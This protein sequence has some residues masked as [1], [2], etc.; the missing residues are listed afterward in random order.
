MESFVLQDW[1]TIRGASG[2][3]VTQGES[4]WLDLAPYEDIV[5]W[6]LVSEVTGTPTPVLLFQ[7]APTK[8]ESFFAAQ[9]LGMTG[10]SVSLVPG[11]ATSGITP[12][13]AWS[14]PFPLARY[15]RWQ[16]P[17]VTS[18]WDVTLRIMVSVS[19]PRT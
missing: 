3:T 7:T 1:V 18:A 11:S 6:L 8:D 9:T 16:I 5:F 17:A 13:F 14:S 19:S 4:S 10:S 12:A 2:V 15:V